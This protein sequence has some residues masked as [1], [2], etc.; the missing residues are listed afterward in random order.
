MLDMRYLTMWNNSALEFQNFQM[1]SVKLSVP[2]FIYKSTLV[3]PIN[4]H[5]VFGKIYEDLHDVLR[6]RRCWGML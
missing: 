1:F 4:L 6:N 5:V 2:V 3:D